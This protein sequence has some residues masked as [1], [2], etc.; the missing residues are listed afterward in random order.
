MIREEEQAAEERE[1]EAIRRALA[2]ERRSAEEASLRRHDAADRDADAFRE[3]RRAAHSAARELLQDQMYLRGGHTEPSASSSMP[4]P[5]P[6]LQSLLPTSGAAAT[7]PSQS[8]LAGGPSRDRMGYPTQSRQTSSTAGAIISPDLYSKWKAEELLCMVETAGQ[9]LLTAM[10]TLRRDASGRIAKE[11]LEAVYDAMNAPDV[12]ANR[13]NRARGRSGDRMQLGAT[14]DI[15]MELLAEVRANHP[16]GS[17]ATAAVNA[18]QA[19]RMSRQE[20][21][22]ELNDWYVRETQEYNREVEEYNAARVMPTAYSGHYNK[23]SN[24]V[25]PPLSKSKYA[26]MERSRRLN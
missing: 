15:M 11:S 7:I 10:S 5:A 4:A 18:E 21:E 17:A 19:Y 2:R 22:R 26:G 23:A 12:V 6:A 8:T 25:V 16:P 24:V 9:P 14:Q 3:A 1:E 13:N 20:Y